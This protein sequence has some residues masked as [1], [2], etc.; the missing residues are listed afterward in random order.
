MKRGFGLFLSAL[1][2]TAGILTAEQTKAPRESPVTKVRTFFS[3]D[4]L[5]RAYYSPKKPVQSSP[6]F[7]RT[8]MHSGGDEAGG[9]SGWYCWPCSIPQPP[10]ECQAGI[11]PG[12]VGTCR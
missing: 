8:M 10:P 12:C 5:F 11:D 2:I 6:R 9:N 7:R 4:G 1:M 3:L